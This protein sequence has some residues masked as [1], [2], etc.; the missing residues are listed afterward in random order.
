M[1]TTRMSDPFLTRRSM[2]SSSATT[3]TGIISSESSSSISTLDGRF[4]RKRK[5][6]F[7]ISKFTYI[8][9]DDEM[10]YS[11]PVNIDEL[12][13]TKADFY[14]IHL[15]NALTLRL[16]ETKDPKVFEDE[17]ESGFCSRGVEELSHEWSR[18][19]HMSYFFMVRG[20]ME[21]QCRQREEL[22]F[23]D[24][25]SLAEKAMQVSTLDKVRALNQGL[26][27]AYEARKILKVYKEQDDHEPTEEEDCDEEEELMTSVF[28][29]IK[30]NRKHPSDAS[31]S[32]ASRSSC[33]SS[34]TASTLLVDD[35]SE[36][37]SRY[38]D[39]HGCDYWEENGPKSTTIL[40]ARPNPFQSFLRIFH[41]PK[42]CLTS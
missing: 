11:P 34:S 9:P 31:D 28:K 40:E 39:D 7:K 6:H 1:S 20:V 37:S 30:Q 35:L 32:L 17:E 26:Q 33:D 29:K 18:R 15:E 41:Q 21:E 12:Y 16:L 3:S 25:I 24:P 10:K 2:S 38:H 42:V 19:R 8:E 36:D 14:R 23:S 27:D 5:V 13:Y 22:Q 4:N